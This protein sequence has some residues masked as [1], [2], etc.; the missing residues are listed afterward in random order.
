MSIKGSKRKVSTKRAKQ[1]DA[2]EEKKAYG[3]NPYGYD[4]LHPF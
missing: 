1:A 3:G 4:Y 2:E